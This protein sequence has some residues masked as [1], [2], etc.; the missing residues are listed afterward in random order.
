[1]G[2][3]R[4]GCNQSALLGNAVVVSLCLWLGLSSL[5]R[6][7]TFMIAPTISMRHCLS[8]TGYSFFAWNLSLLLSYPLENYQQNSYQNTQQYSQSQSTTQQ[9]TPSQSQQYSQYNTQNTQYQQN[10]QNQQQNGSN[11]HENKTVPVFLFLVLFGIPSSIAQG[12][13]KSVV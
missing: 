3:T 2:V 10:T 1:M 11:V 6:I 9:Y 13:R 8:I 5:Y 12:D 7:L 4:H